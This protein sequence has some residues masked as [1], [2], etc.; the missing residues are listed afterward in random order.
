M[1]P[2]VLY[3]HLYLASDRLLHHIGQRAACFLYHSLFSFCDVDKLS[4]ANH[5]KN[6]IRKRRKRK[7]LND[8]NNILNADR[9]VTPATSPQTS[10]FI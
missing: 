10:G 5:D 8:K 1:L 6:T 2:H 4:F 3:A 7:G 9:P